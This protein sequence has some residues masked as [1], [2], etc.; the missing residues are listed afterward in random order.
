MTIRIELELDMESYKAKYGP[1][2]EWAKKY[3][4]SNWDHMQSNSN[5]LKEAI[6]DVLQEGFYDW[7]SQGWMKVQVLAS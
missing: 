3:G 7:A 2:S 6:E 4:E 1:G 5:W